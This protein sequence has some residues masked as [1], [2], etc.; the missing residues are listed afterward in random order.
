MGEVAAVRPRLR[1]SERLL[2]D[3]RQRFIVAAKNGEANTIH[4]PPYSAPAMLRPGQPVAGA[5]VPAAGWFRT[6][7]VRCAR[8]LARIV[9]LRSRARPFSGVGRRRG[10]RWL[11]G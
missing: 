3:A 5:R 2:G 8:A 10:T 4:P 1:Q 6:S 9:G 11:P 7:G